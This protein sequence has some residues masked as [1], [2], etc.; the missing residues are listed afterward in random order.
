MPNYC[1]YEMKI[2]GKKENVLRMVAYLQADYNYQ[3]GLSNCTED[4]HFFRVFEANVIDEA[5]LSSE[6]YMAVVSG[7]CAWSISC[8][9]L[10]GSLSYYRNWSEE[11]L[12]TLKEPF[13]GTHLEDV[14]KEL[15]LS[16]EIFSKESGLEFMEH[17]IVESGTITLDET[18][19]YHE[20][21]DEEADEWIPVGGVEWAYT[22]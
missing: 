3:D 18:H 19:D 22:I 20:E 9:M 13:K 16:V 4:K 12:S 1:D 14:T 6:T 8:C 10:Q 17:Y 21:Y 5:E 15:D 7:Y 11:R 2:L